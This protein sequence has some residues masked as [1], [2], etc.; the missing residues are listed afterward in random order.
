MPI[1]KKS[2]QRKCGNYRG[3]TL[4]SI[5]EKVFAG[6]LNVR[7]RLLTDKRLLEEQASF[8]SVGGALI[9]SL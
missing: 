4:L 1:H 2:S 8:R 3:I 7:V 5:P 6:I 9:R